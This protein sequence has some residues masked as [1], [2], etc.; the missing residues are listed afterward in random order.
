PRHVPADPLI[1]PDA[2][3]PD[4]EAELRARLLLYRAFR[5]AGVALQER[6]IATLGLFR[7]EPSTAAA[8]ALAGSRP[9]D[10]PPFDRAVLVDAL[11]ALV[12]V[13]PEPA[14]PPAVVQRRIRIA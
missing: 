4:P 5:D 12:Q 7:R 2:A 8:A 13:V 6:A 3:T 11:A 9:A 10:E 1:D 14:A